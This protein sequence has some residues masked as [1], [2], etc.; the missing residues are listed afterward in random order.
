MFNAAVLNAKQNAVYYPI[1]ITLGS[2]ASG[3]ALWRGGWLTLNDEISLGTLV[4]F[5]NFAGMFFNPINQLAQRLT[6]IQSAQAAG[7]RVMSLLETTPAIQDR[8]E[9]LARIE[10]HKAE[11]SHSAASDLAIDG[12][13]AK[14]ESIEFR[15]VT[16]RYSTGPTVLEKFNLT[17]K[18]G[19][20]IALVGPSGGGKSTIVSMVC[21]FYEPVEG[22]ILIN[23]IDYRERSLA[24]H[25]VANTAPVQRHDSRKYSLRSSRGH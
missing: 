1:V 19:E 25:C 21:R 12:L 18:A 24:W 22:Q 7:E 20:T 17:V 10:K 4:A 14:V 16:F 2:L 3:I 5:V 15:D 6:E 9:V 13:P 23:G 11:T 8:P